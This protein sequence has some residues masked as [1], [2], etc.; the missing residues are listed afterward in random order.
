M[1]L[2]VVW[3]RLSCMVARTSA[4]TADFSGI[5]AVR[6]VTSTSCHPDRS[7]LASGAEGS[8][9]LGAS[10]PRSLDFARKLAPLGMTKVDHQSSCK[11]LYLMILAMSNG[12]FFR[13]RY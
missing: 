3:L 13:L 6:C 8:R 4:N 5:D 2:S 10:R 11:P 7:E 9:Q 1:T 12:A